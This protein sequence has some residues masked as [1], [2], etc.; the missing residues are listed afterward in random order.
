MDLIQTYFVMGVSTLVKK[1]SEDS[2]GSAL[3]AIKTFALLVSSKKRLT[4][5]I[6][7]SSS[8]MMTT[9]QQSRNFNFKIIIFF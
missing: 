3:R 1:K 9:R 4:T 8:A 5:R 6:T 7:I 2:A